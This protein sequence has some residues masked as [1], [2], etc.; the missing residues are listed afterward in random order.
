MVAN[1]A[2]KGYIWGMVQR[3]YTAPEP[4]PVVEDSLTAEQNARLLQSIARGE[5]QFQAGEGIPGDEVFAWL[6][7]LGTEKELP[8]PRREPRRG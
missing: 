8:R 7:S 4:A 5:A 3:I 6:R 1:E 2:G